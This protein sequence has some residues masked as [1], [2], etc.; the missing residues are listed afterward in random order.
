MNNEADKLVAEQF[1]SLPPNTKRAIDSIPW[2]QRVKEVANTNNLDQNQ[3]TLLEQETVFVLIGLEKFGDY[4]SNIIKEVGLSE[5]TAC[6]V[7][8]AIADRV[9]DPI[10]E[11]IDKSNGDSKISSNFPEIAPEIH[12]VIEK[13]EVVHDVKPSTFGEKKEKANLPDYRYPGGVDP[14]REPTN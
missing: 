10:L 11:I 2:R 13:G 14:Y 1:N 3:A 7:T 4:I 9:F 5:E 6:S 12:P 8:Q